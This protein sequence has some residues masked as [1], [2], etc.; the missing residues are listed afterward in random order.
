[1]LASYS[2][3]FKTGNHCEGGIPEKGSK[4]A[5]VAGAGRDPGVLEGT[6]KD[7]FNPKNADH[8]IIQEAEIQAARS[9]A[10]FDSPDFTKDLTDMFTT[11]RKVANEWCTKPSRL[12]AG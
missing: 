5:H 11:T 3:G 1:V 4:P 9:Y 8:L 6:Q 7:T 12:P 10:A 2:A